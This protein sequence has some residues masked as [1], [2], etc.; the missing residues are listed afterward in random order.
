MKKW[1][2]FGLAATMAIAV[3]CGGDARTPV[4]P[5]S[6]AAASAGAASDG[7][8]L[9]VTAPTPQSPADGTRLPD[10][11]PTLVFGASIGKY[12]DAG[13]LTYRL[14]TVDAAGTEVVNV[15]GIS[16]AARQYAFTADLAVNA[17]YRWQVRAESGS[18]VGPWSNLIS[19]I[20]A[21]KPKL[22]TLKSYQTATELWDNLA[23][24]KTIGV[25]T[26]MDF[27]KDVGART[28]SNES[29]IRYD[30][31]QTM[32]AGE[33]SFY[34][35]NLN[36]LSTGDKTKLMSMAEGLGDITTND[37]RFTV[38]KRGSS[39]TKPGQV[40]IRVIA[41]DSDE[42]A[43]RIFDSASQVPPLVKAV[44]Y[45]V[46]LTWGGS[47]VKWQVFAADGTTGVIGSKVAE[48]NM[49]YGSFTYKPV[50]HMAYVGAPVGR[51]GPNDASVSNMT[52]KFLWIGGPGTKR[53]GTF[54]PLPMLDFGFEGPGF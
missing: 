48:V 13:T 33:F 45:F 22:E 9:K 16:G 34:V 32:N 1:F 35:F 24:G 39:Y 43:G 47:R 46:R 44:W 6:T 37:Y 14:R 52:V 36:P 40:R 31:L 28:I 20:T 42:H 12:V 19:F 15:S 18:H 5:S 23:D 27:T 38:E 4:S 50:P 17:T 11:K 10:F 25:A 49:G 41:G 26:G 7:S 53:P 21:D 3:A 54:A 30:L 51:A 29:N 2:L 8:T